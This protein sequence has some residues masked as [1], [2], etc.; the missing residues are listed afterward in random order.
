LPR[1]QQ[2]PPTYVGTADPKPE[3]PMRNF[4]AVLALVLGAGLC[5]APAAT[6]QL[7]PIKAALGGGPSAPLGDLAD[8][9]GSGFHAQGS[10]AL[11]LP[12]LP[13][14]VRGDLLFQ[15]LPGEVSGNHRQLAAIA[16]VSFAMP[17]LLVRPYLIGGAGLY[18]ARFDAPGAGT[19]GSSTD[20]GF[21]VG[22]GVRLNLIALGVFGEARLH[23][24]MTE[25]SA[26]RF[27]PITVGITF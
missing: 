5:A 14:G 21:N 10:V 19:G 20:T 26:T 11:E 12:L 1:A 2:P 9:V 4:A 8:H 13:V 7:F 24:V 22:L 6:A 16:N 3:N 27:V 18:R 23:N 17:L 15:Q 25:G